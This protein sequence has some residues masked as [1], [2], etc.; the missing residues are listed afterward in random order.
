MLL[1]LRDSTRR[2]A[3][4]IRVGLRQKG[5]GLKIDITE[6]GEAGNVDNRRPSVLISPY[7]I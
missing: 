2:A 5:N 3:S 4:Y 6:R 7:K 1:I